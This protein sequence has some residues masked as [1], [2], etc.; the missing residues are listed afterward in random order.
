MMDKTELKQTIASINLDNIE[1]KLRSNLFWEDEH[2]YNSRSVSEQGNELDECSTAI[3]H[4]EILRDAL[5]AY[6][7]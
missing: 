5:E 3:S 7:K 4:F 1:S 6:L 2:G